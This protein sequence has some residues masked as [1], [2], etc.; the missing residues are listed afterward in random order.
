MKNLMNNNSHSN[1]KTNDSDALE[2]KIFSSYTSFLTP[3]RGKDMYEAT[4]NNNNN[5]SNNF[6]EHS[7]HKRNL[8][9]EIGSMRYY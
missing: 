4:T 3:G 1:S 9:K 6:P 8:L 7:S 2:N 5:N